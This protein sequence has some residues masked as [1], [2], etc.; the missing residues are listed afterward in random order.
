MVYNKQMNELLFKLILCHLTGDYVLQL[1]FIAKSK[2]T[3]MYNLIVHCVLYLVPFYITFGFN[4]KLF[5]IFI[6]HL[7]VDLLKARYKKINYFCDQ[8]LHYLILLIYFV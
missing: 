4:W 2:G 3:N 1:D 6:T 7:I 5:V 8:M